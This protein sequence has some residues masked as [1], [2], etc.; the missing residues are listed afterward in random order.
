MLEGKSMPSNMAAS[1][2]PHVP[3]EDWSIVIDFYRLIDTIDINQIRFTEFIDLSIAKSVPIVIDWL[4]R[5]YFKDVIQY[6]YCQFS[7]VSA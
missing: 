6:F 4:L 7:P 3:S 5:A 2:H 1:I